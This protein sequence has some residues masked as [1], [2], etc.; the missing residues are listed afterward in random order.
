MRAYIPTPSHPFF[1]VGALT[2]HYYAICILIGIFA[3]YKIS[4]IRLPNYK[5]TVSDLL[6][7]VVPAGIIGARIFHVIT[8]PEKYFNHNFLDVFKVWQGGLGIWGAIAG[9]AI[10]GYWRLKSKGLQNQFFVFAD[11]MAP[12]LLIA[13]AIGRFGNW[14]NGE[15]FGGPTKLPWGL[16]IPTSN[17]PKDFV[18]FTTFHPTFLYE[19]IWCVVIAIFLL[20]LKNNVP[21][22]IFWLYISLYSFG[23][24]FIE[25]LRSDY[26]HYLFG[27]RV[28]IW[29]SLFF[30][31]LG[32]RNYWKLRRA[33][34]E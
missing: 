15:L 20:S 3:A 26:A 28:N 22:Q 8:T 33:K 13:Q 14:F 31:L 21:G 30:I 10:A 34:V 11:G 7:F 27:V 24:I 25:S 2:I 32:A 18:N 12:G 23:R 16:Q 4:L 1:S 17:R 6:I 9:G 5:E 29:T 19:A